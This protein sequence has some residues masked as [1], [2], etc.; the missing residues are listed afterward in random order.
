MKKKKIAII[1][2]L[3]NFFFSYVVYF[4]KNNNVRF[5]AVNRKRKKTF[6]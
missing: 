3:M 2:H 5:E 6:K 1:F 4:I